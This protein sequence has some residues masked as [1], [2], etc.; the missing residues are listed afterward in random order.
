[1]FYRPLGCILRPHDEFK[2]DLAKH[3]FFPQ[4]RPL[5]EVFD[6][7]KRWQKPY[8]QSQLG[9]CT[10]NGLAGTCH[11][12]LIRE[13]KQKGL[14]VDAPAQIPSRLFIYYNERASEGTIDQDAGALIHDG[15]KVVAS[16]GFCFED[17]LPYDISKFT[18]TPEHACYQVGYQHRIKSYH[19]VD[20]TNLNAIKATLAGDN[21][22]VFGFNVYPSFNNVGKDGLMP[23][24]KRGE[25]PEGGHCVVWVGYDDSRRVLI[26]RNSWGTDWADGGYFYMPYDFATNPNECSD[27]WTINAVP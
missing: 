20:L 5:P 13:G 26:T 23:M 11:Y 21:P 2:L 3:Q 1:M 17:L 4:A 24:P 18:E 7:R 25:T 14:D 9:S 16:K 27:S 6:P 12:I 22:I 19:A 10:G 8:D 15:V